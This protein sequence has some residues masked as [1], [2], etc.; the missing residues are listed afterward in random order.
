MCKSWC[1][2]IL[3]VI[4]I[5]VSL[6]QL[7]VSSWAGIGM[8]IVLIVG[9]VLLAHSFTCKVCFNDSMVKRKR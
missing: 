1:E 8:W 9:I 2:A 6:W 7:A 3:A 5:V 4:L